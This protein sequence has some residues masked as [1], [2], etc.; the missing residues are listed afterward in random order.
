MT[1]RA[2][3]TLDSEAFSFLEKMAGNN[4]SAYINALLK[5]EQRRSLEQAIIQSNQEEASDMA[6]QE[7]LATWEPTLADGLEPL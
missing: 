6:Y 1:H 2:T 7:E 5:T 3:I 4:R